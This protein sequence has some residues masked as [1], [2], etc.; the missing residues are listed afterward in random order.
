MD[1]NILRVLMKGFEKAFF[2]LGSELWED[3]FSSLLDLVKV[4][5]GYYNRI[6]EQ[7]KI[8]AFHSPNLRLHLGHWRMLGMVVG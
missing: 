1:L 8:L 5:K 7:R 6:Y 4:K 2:V 3:G